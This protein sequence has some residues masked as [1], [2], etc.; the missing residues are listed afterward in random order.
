LKTEDLKRFM[1]KHP[2]WKIFP[3]HPLNLALKKSRFKEPKE[4]EDKQSG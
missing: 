1:E 2:Y 3:W 4:K